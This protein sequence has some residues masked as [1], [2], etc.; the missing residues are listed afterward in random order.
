MGVG[1]VETD[2]SE[3][4]DQ[5]KTTSKQEKRCINTRAA[6]R[7]QKAT[8]AK[9]PSPFALPLPC[10]TYTGQRIHESTTTR[11][12]RQTVA[13]PSTLINPTSKHVFVEL[14]PLFPPPPPLSLVLR[15]RRAVASPTPSR[16]Y[17][18][19]AAT[20]R[21]HLTETCRHGL[22]RRRPRQPAVQRA[23][24]TVD[25]TRKFALE[26]RRRQAHSFTTARNPPLRR[27]AHQVPQNQVLVARR[28]QPAYTSAIATKLTERL[29]STR[30]C[31]FRYAL[32]QGRPSARQAT[33]RRT[34]G[35]H[36]AIS[37]LAP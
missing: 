29:A 11:T 24:L 22:P 14:K 20:R 31:R 15:P 7:L 16:L 27:H 19:A 28:S 32:R 2:F 33:T 25:F 10:L 18:P 9:G 35:A 37:G 6:S 1:R 8:A 30:R 36:H 26:L 23:H 3:H 21:L 13:R 4:A 12:G 5:E 17:L 34:K